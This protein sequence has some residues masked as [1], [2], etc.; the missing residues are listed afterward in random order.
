MTGAAISNSVKPDGCCDEERALR[1][2]LTDC[3]HL[4]DHMGWSE[5]IFNHISAR[6]PG[7]AQLR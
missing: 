7:D 2:R 1:C 5:T 4:V 6:L 3:H